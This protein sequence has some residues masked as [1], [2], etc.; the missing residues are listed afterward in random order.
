MSEFT[1]IGKILAVL[2]AEQD[3]Y[4]YVDKIGYAPSRD[5]AIFYLKEAIRDFHSLLRRGEFENKS[6]KKEAEK[7]N[8]NRVEYEIRKMSNISDRKELRE[9]LSLI[10]ALALTISARLKGEV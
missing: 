4:T 7:I 2:V 9:K 1:E 3:S 6:A 10:A 8:Y 5:L